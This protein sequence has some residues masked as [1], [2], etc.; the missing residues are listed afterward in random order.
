MIIIYCVFRDFEEAQTIGEV[1][2]QKKL[3][4]C[5]NLWTIDSCY[6][7]KGKIEKARECAAFI[8]TGRAK[9]GKVKEVI[10]QHHSYEIPCI[11]ELPIGRG[12]VEGTYLQWVKTS[13]RE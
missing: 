9:F 6:R 10:R 7:W 12:R 4:A 1:L 3:A 8:K 11:I 2:I 5:I 13:V